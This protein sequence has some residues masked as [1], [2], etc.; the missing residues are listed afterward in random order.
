MGE[1]KKIHKE[2]KRRNSFSAELKRIASRDINKRFLD[3]L[4]P[5]KLYFYENTKDKK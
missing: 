1:K 5:E 2:N 4:F 3:F